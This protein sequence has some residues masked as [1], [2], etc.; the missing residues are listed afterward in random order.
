[1]ARTERP[2]WISRFQEVMDAK[3]LG[4]R[5][6]AGKIAELSGGKTPDGGSAENLRA[7]REGRVRNP[8]PAIMKLVAQAL[9]VRYEWLLGEDDG[10]MTDQEDRVAEIERQLGEGLPG[11][12]RRIWAIRNLGGDPDPDG[13]DRIPD[14]QMSPAM[15]LRAK[16]ASNEGVVFDSSFV[17]PA[18]FLTWR[19]LAQLRSPQLTGE[20]VDELGASLLDRMLDF[21]D[22]AQDLNG[23]RKRRTVKW[24]TDVL[25]AWLNA[26]AVTVAWD[27]EDA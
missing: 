26:V 2:E 24:R 13:W 10:P 14:A 19:R 21:L 17:L 7:Y 5:R 23:G 11:A 8:R 22:I 6:L 15:K 4:H 20:Q 27:R 9:G 25:L 12:N 16:E 1:M 3:G 18:Y